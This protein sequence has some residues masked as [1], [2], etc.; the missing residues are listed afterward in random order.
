MAIDIRLDT[1]DNNQKTLMGI[2]DISGHLVRKFKINDPRFTRIVWNGRD[3]TGETVKT[4]VYFI[5]IQTKYGE[6]VRSKKII[7]IK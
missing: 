2:Y 7:F 6:Q 5:K 3:K 4:G 1:K